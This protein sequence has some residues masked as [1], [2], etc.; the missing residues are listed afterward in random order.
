[1]DIRLKISRLVRHYKTRNPFEL[2]EALGI[3][4][5][6]EELGSINGYY[7]KQFRMK[8]I[9]INHNLPDNMKLLT[10]AHELGHALLHPDAATPFLRSCTFLSV[11]RMELEANTF[12][13]ELLLPDEVI[14][15][16][17]SH[18]LDEVA[19]LTGYAKEFIK[20]KLRNLK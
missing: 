3:K 9:H 14:Y 4:V 2:A 16:H 11:D 6:Y 19:R 1:M 20:L 7:N 15:S 10:C 17:K 8:Q 5:I 12:A 18:T 13:I